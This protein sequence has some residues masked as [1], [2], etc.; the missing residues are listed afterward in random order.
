MDF[1]TSLV[2][3]MGSSNLKSLAELNRDYVNNSGNAMRNKPFWN[4]LS[5]P[6]CLEFMLEGKNII[7]KAYNKGVCEHPYWDGEELFQ[8]I[9]SYGLQ[10]IVDVPLYDGTYFKLR[11][12]WRICIPEQERTSVIF[13]WKM[14]STRMVIH[15]TRKQRMQE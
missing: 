8:I 14:Y 2:T 12:N 7:E 9:R 4:K 6:E 5:E 10:N 3:S 15:A 13:C 11:G 1:F